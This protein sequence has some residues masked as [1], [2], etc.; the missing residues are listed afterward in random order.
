M[1]KLTM[2]M[3]AVV[4]LLHGLTL[5][6]ASASTATEQQDVTSTAMSST[7]LEQED[8][9]AVCSEF[10]SNPELVNQ[11][12][13]DLRPL[14]MHVPKCGSTFAQAL[15][16]VHCPWIDFH[17]TEPVLEVHNYNKNGRKCHH[18]MTRFKSGHAGG[19]R[20]EHKVPLVVT[21]LRH[22]VSRLISGFFHNFHDCTNMKNRYKLRHKHVTD[23][24][25]W[26]NMIANETIVL[27]YAKC[28][29]GM[30][31]LMLNGY[32]RKHVPFQEP[33]VEETATAIRRIMHI[34]F[35]GI[36]EEWNK[37][38]C[39]YRAM[40]GRKDMSTLPFAAGRVSPHKDELRMKLRAALERLGW[41]DE[42]EH[43]VYESAL[44]RFRKDEHKY[45]LHN[46]VP[47][48]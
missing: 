4:L 7:M 31:T 29:Q 34:A 23:T 15:A 48:P 41:H 18:G 36:Q 37:S 35:V 43:M 44:L 42:A 16:E 5:A 28:T 21:M 47:E 24:Q 2:W 12:G 32:Y 39:L 17:P 26:E 1:V 33:T 8:A 11:T 46:T 10:T 40:Y 9:M 20:K 13:V 38:V 3:V 25:F 27:E 14:Y 6:T 22:P 30:A 45:L 19:P